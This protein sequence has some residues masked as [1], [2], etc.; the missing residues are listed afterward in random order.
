MVALGD[1]LG[2]H[3]NAV[4]A[5]ALSVDALHGAVI[6]CEKRGQLV[7]RNRIVVSYHFWRDFIVS[8]SSCRPMEHFSLVALTFEA[9]VY[10]TNPEIA[11]PEK[12]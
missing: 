9:L 1:T 3:Q 12:V 8:L 5:Y 11:Y 4:I 10:Q 6:N 2:T 7:I